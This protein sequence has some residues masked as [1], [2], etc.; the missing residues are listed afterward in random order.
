MF[1]DL[2]KIVNLVRKSVSGLVKLGKE[3]ERRAATLE[4]L[5]MYFLIYD[6]CKDGRQ[7]L[8]SATDNPVAYIKSLEGTALDAQMKVWNAI[9]RRQG[10]RLYEAQSYVSASSY[11]AVIDPEAQRGIEE[12]IGYKMNR[13]ANLHGLGA[14]L[15]FRAMLPVKETPAETAELVAHILTMEEAALLEPEAILDELAKLES[16][17]DEFRQLIMAVIEKNDFV[18]LA[19]EARHATQKGSA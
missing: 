15:F 17:L 4:M 7:L 6:A 16:G 2:L 8:E 9:L 10:V 3:S 13:V 14:G 12:V 11:L 1:V 18:Q 5:K 19:D